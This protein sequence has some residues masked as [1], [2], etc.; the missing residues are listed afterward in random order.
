MF[1]QSYSL[2]QAFCHYT[3]LNP[4]CPSMPEV[5]DTPVPSFD[6][7]CFSTG[8]LRSVRLT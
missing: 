1:P 3:S 7:L 6:A 4:K 8:F 2:K 5:M